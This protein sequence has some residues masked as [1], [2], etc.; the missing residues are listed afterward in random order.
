MKTS[1][2]KTRQIRKP[3][4]RQSFVHSIGFN[5][6]LIILIA[7]IPMVAWYIY[8]YISDR[9]RAVREAGDRALETARQAASA[10]EKLIDSTRQL[11]IA[12]SSVPEVNDWEAPACGKFLEHLRA[13]MDQYTDLGVADRDGNVICSALPV[14]DNVRLDDPSIIQ[15]V[16]RDSEFSISRYH[17]R[18]GRDSG[19]INFG[20]PIMNADGAD[21]GIVYASVDL[22]WL[23]LLLSST[24][25]P[26]GAGATV[27]DRS[28]VVLA[29][30]PDPEVWVGKNVREY[31]LFS[32]ILDQQSGI[33]Q[34][35]G[36]DA[37]M[38]FHAFLPLYGDGSNLFIEAGIP[39]QPVYD[40]IR[41][42]LVRNMSFLGLIAAVTMLAMYI[43]GELLILRRVRHITGVATR[44]ASGDLNARSGME[45][46]FGQ[47][48]QLG[49]TIDRMAEKLQKNETQLQRS[50]YEARERAEQLEMLYDAGI[51]LNEQ[52]DHRQQLK[53]LFETAMKTVNAERAEFFRLVPGKELLLFDMDLGKRSLN[54]EELK[55]KEFFIGASDGFVGKVAQ[56]RSMHVIPDLD[57]YPHN[58]PLDPG[59]RSGLFSPIEHKGN[60][61]GVLALYSVRHDAF[62]GQ[63]EKWINL[64]ASQAAVAMTNAGLI[65]EITHRLEQIEGLREIDRAISGSFDLRVTSNVVLDQVMRNLRVDAADILQA[66]PETQTLEFVSGRGFRS[67]ILQHASLP[68]GESLAGR[69]ALERSI[70]SIPDLLEDV[71]SGSTPTFIAGEGFVSYFA[72]PL[73]AKGSVKGVLELFHRQPLSADPDWL[74]FAEI[75]ASQAAIALDNLSM[76][77]EVIDANRELSLA[78]DR[79]I[80]GW[81]VA[82]D[83]R[84]RETEGHAQR[85]TSM[86]LQLAR[87]MELP[88]SELVQIRRGALL[89]D[90]GK[91]GIPDSILQKPGELT[92]EEWET[93]MKHP[94]YAF[95][96]LSSISYLRTALEIPYCHHEKWDGSGYP[97]GLKGEQIPL[98]ARIFAVVDVWDALTSDRPYRAAWPRVKAMLY[99]RKQAGVHFDPR[100]VDRFIKLDPG[101]IQ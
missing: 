36:L 9:D 11:L 3:L 51:N 5:F 73:I 38:G 33:I 43:L 84:D 1:D 41:D 65:N 30:Y 13:D 34:G 15:Q 91:M 26:D 77:N 96:M 75:L 81:A 94:F 99:I 16:V 25:F 27:L 56:S 89:H 100:V 72:L 64:F 86:T 31:P 57:L 61:L 66:H 23:A 40:E 80:E 58:M 71:H 7:Y 67:R 82:L 12:L 53:S 83:L 55:K 2:Q 19:Y 28:G 14:G 50:F 29:R 74:H 88:D 79:T 76:F 47:I 59:L 49:F 90:I 39:G 62:T 35:N 95:R 48:S 10:Q 101:E 42:T 8:M 20:Y 24:D 45:N 4:P 52:L 78:Y 87:E 22:D 98:P 6:V 60:L 92:A 70:V 18:P 32:S 63:H 93:M 17:S 44:L 85:V 37:G 69:A 68:I 46:R 97:R 54:I 21:K